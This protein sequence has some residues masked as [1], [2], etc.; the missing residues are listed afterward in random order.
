MCVSGN[1][2]IFESGCKLSI[3]DIEINNSKKIF[4]GG[5]TISF[6]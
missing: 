5:G 6:K 4:V 3:N 1:S 2:I